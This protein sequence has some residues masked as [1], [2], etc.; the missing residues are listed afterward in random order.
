VKA[1]ASLPAAAPAYSR[2]EH[3]PIVFVNGI[4]ESRLIARELRVN[5][6]LDRRSAFLAMTSTENTAVLL[7]HW[8]KATIT[9][10]MPN[11]LV[12]E[13]VRWPVLVHGRLAGDH[14]Q[15][16]ATSDEQILALVDRWDLLLDEP[17][18]SIWWQTDEGLLFDEVESA[19]MRIGDGANRSELAWTIAGEQV[20]VFQ[21]DGQLWTLGTALTAVSAFAG[22]DLS[23]KWLPAE[24]RN[25]PLVQEIDLGHTIGRVLSRILEP[26]GLVIQRDLVRES[27]TVIERRS[28]RPAA[29]GR[30]I[31]LAWADG[32]R[33]LGQVL[34]VVTDRPP[35]AAQ[36]WVA[37][38]DGWLIE[39]TFELIKAWD[40]ALEGAPDS[41]YSKVNNA[42][43]STYANVFRFWALNEDGRFSEFPYNQGGAYDLATFFEHFPIRPRPLRFLPALTQ[44]DTG[45][46]RSPI[47]EISTDNGSSWS[48]YPG[49]ARVRT[50]RAAVYLD[51]TTLPSSFL[52]AAQTGN[53]KVRVTASLR[54]PVPVEVLRW[55]GNPFAGT[56]PTKVFDLGNAFRFQRVAPESIHSAGILSGTLKADQIDQTATMN[57]WLINRQRRADVF[58]DNEAGKATL[59]LSGIWPLLRIGDQWIN[60]SGSGFDASGRAEAIASKGAIVNSVRC[61]WS[62]GFVNDG[63]NRASGAGRAPMT[64]VG[65]NF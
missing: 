28:V 22:L 14:D 31:H 18:A 42:A 63:R 23:L 12:D 36:P 32:Q 30:V 16:S 7:E 11:R 53:A 47:V 65:I 5:G 60:T 21:N 57:N 37:Q 4:P 33:P 39:S 55:S 35:Q 15:L 29:R 43:F 40:P 6:P 25:L 44:D 46:R 50:D 10:A 24:V 41:S 58:V 13:Q 52:A 26:Y 61:R 62:D 20:H 48:V 2:P 59:K 64:I 27:A 38:A 19:V 56:S 49:T 51:D 9:L 34:S 45:V 3:K 1:C 8:R 54:S 17:L